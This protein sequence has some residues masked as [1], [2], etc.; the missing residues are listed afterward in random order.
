LTALTL[1]SHN[2]CPYVQRAAIALAEKRVGFERV[3]VDLSDKP[4]WFRAISPLGKVPLLRVA[5][6]GGEQVIFESAVILEYL[7]ETQ[8][9]PLHPDHP[10]DRARHRSWIEF[11]SVLLNGIA[12]L[13]NAGTQASFEQECDSLRAGF[14]RLETELSTRRSGS[15]FQR[16]QFTLVDA[17]FGPIF[18]YFDVFE[19]RAGL[20]LLDGLPRIGA[21]RAALAERPSVRGAV[22]DD[23]PE[24]LAAFLRNRKAYMSGLVA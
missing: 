3:Y 2:L 10:L 6:G 9:N 23:Y 7:E 8:A 13:Y 16:N 14:E 24:L 12:R 11:G 17:V 1:V 5:S 20:R 22:D 19:A 18:R 4:D 21:W 15:F